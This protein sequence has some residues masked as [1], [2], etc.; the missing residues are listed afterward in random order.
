LVPTRQGQA[1][2]NQHEEA[3]QQLG[4]LAQLWSCIW[5]IG[6]NWSAGRRADR[7]SGEKTSA[8]GGHTFG[9]MPDAYV[10]I[11]LTVVLVTMALLALAL[12]LPE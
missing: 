7:A 3:L 4:T 2:A 12:L 6:D 10:L 5:A 9:G 8:A 11:P 1:D